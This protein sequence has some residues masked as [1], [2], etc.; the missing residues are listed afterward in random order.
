MKVKSIGLTSLHAASH[1]EFMQ[2]AYKLL[3]IT[4]ALAIPALV[5]LLPLWLADIN[6]ENTLIRRQRGSALTPQVQAADKKRDDIM[7]ELF[8]SIEAGLK[9]T[10]AAKKQASESLEIIIRPY[11]KDA[12]DQLTDQTQDLDGM[13]AALGA[14][15]AFDA[16]EVLVLGG[17]IQRLR[18]A[19]NA[20]KTVYAERIAESETRAAMN[21][22]KTP[23]QRRIV[24]NH[25]HTATDLLE[26]GSLMLT[27][28]DRTAVEG[29]IGSLNALVE[30]YKLVIANQAKTRTA[31]DDKIDREVDKLRMQAANAEIKQKRLEEK[32]ARA[33]EK[34]AEK[35]RQAEEKGKRRG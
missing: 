9:S 4:P 35:L 26:A 17:V 23:D 10:D 8:Y 25:Y 6:I 13:L 14:D 18:Q 27:A 12:Y 16:S 21:E 20:F 11:R 29:V 28:A 19:N 32:A 5:E 3:N 1:V 22:V 24:D 7:Y 31:G 15:D 33:A 34:A 30:Q 2:S